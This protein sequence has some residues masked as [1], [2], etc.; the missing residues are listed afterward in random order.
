MPNGVRHLLGV[1]IGVV[2][3]PCVYLGLTY[4]PEQT[5]RQLQNF[6]SPASTWPWLL[7]LAAAA[8]LVGV[9]ATWRWVSPLASLVTGLPLIA[10]GLAWV[11]MPSFATDLT[12]TLN[13]FAATLGGVSGSSGLY[14]AVGVVLLPACVSPARWRGRTRRAPAHAAPSGSAA[15][16]AS[17][18]SADEDK[19]DSPDQSSGP[20]TQ[21]WTA[22]SPGKAQP[23]PAPQQET[24]A[25]SLFQP[26]HNQPATP[27]S[28]PPLPK[29]R[30]SSSSS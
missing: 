23:A 19:P 1:L 30:P 5:V 21:P 27:S 7:A 26:A 17:T 13:V 25:G 3:L 18:A 16:K 8:L 12:N 10:L 9:L 15:S 22:I 4:G 20:S 24:T 14:L 2:A 6:A 28:P 29:R 11:F